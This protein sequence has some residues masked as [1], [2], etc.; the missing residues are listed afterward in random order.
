MSHKPS[1]TAAACL[2]TAT[3][4][5]AGTAYAAETAGLEEVV[6]T[7]RK[8]EESARN[9]PVAV[10]A[11]SA[12]TI[13]AAGIQ[14]PRDFIGLTPNVTL[15]ETQNAGN[16]FVTIRGIS[17]AR[18]S[19]PS[20]ATVVDGVIETNPASFNQEL[21]DIQQIEVLKGPQGALYGRNAIGGAILITTKQPS[22]VFEGSLKAGWEDGPGYSLR[23]AVSGPITDTLKFR[24][25]ASYVD[26]DGWLDNTFLN[27]K[28][29]PYQDLSGRA[30]LVW[31][32]SDTFSA[33]LR[34]SASRLETQALYFNINFNNDVND[35]SLP[36]RVNNPGQNDRDLLGAALKMD[37]QFGLGTLTSTTAYDKT[38]EILTGDA[39]NFLPIRESLLFQLFGIDLNQ[40]Q[41][42]E[43]E[44][45]SQ[46]FR[47]TSNTD[48][49]LRWIAGVYAIGTDRYIST[50]NMLDTGNGVFPVYKTPST[51]PLNPQTTFLAD[52]QDNF[53]Y[54]LF[55]DVVYQFSD[56]LE[57]NVALRY[58]HDDRENTTETPTAFLPNVPGFP[59]G[60]TGQKRDETWSELQ[61]KFTLR[62]AIS[63]ASSVYGGWSRGFRSG[64]FNQTGVG[65]VAAS[66]G[67]LGVGDLFDAEV[68]DT[69]E[70]GWKGRYLDDRLSLNA[71]VFNT[72]AEGSYFF[73]FLAANSTQNL[74]NLTKVRYQG[75]EL[76][77]AWRV[78]D[79]LELFAS[80]A[81]TDSEIREA[82]D[83]SQVG[84]QAPLVSRHT[85]NLGAQ[86]RHAL[87]S[88]STELVARVDWRQVGRTWWE[89]SNVTSRDPID[90][91]DA[92]VGVESGPWSV[93]LWGRNIT[94]E[95]YNA[96]FSPG[97]F[98]FKA[99]PRRYGVDVGYS[100]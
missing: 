27:E 9:V 31:T 52:S 45:L 11:F 25:A 3:G 96:E 87:G 55:A 64:G 36:I 53:A 86:Y 12:A 78:T 67:I 49:P 91:V 92:R 23:G 39:F 28:A 14:Q 35:T 59:Q 57:G 90:L 44:F 7:A 68:A 70:L 8:R 18:N 22:D 75:G 47:F 43:V 51:N 34:L 81:F 1:R 26:H 37:W 19:E 2:L 94:D 76:D 46:E 30:R 84:N 77:A 50:G 54:A 98:V 56:R 58:D 13:Q 24:V 100:F 69:T 89:P 65:A 99:K 74:G 4:A 21:F 95:E 97:G 42:L 15:V 79:G 72:E 88:G 60:F 33:D 5:V 48:G 73:V 20:V 80:V 62:Y 17:Q 82:V 61:P 71:A 41:Y 93:T 32:P 16:A 85:Y 66:N 40:S 6:V 63:D 38:E 10:T 29:D 83:R